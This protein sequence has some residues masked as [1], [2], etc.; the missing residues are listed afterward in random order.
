MTHE[1]V[2]VIGASSG[3]GFELVKQFLAEG[4]LVVASSRNV[5]PL[6]ELRAMYG[7]NLKLISMD[8]T[9]S[10]SVQNAVSEIHNQ[11]L[12]IEA[13]LINA[14]GYVPVS[15]TQISED[16]ALS[17]MKVN[18]LGPVSVTER[19]LPGMLEKGHGHIVFVA[20]VA[21]YLGLP[22]SL[23][24]G[25]SKAALINFAEGLRV[26]L[27]K[28]GIKIQLVNPGFVR[29]PLT[30]NNTFKMPF[31]MGASE[32]ATRIVKGME[33]SKFEISFPK[34]FTYFL[35]LLQMLPYGFTLKFLNERTVK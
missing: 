33:G 25:P 35:R 2:W 26:S 20:S 10:S 4:R 1:P 32:A 16:V 6:E 23:A 22:K 3:I 9:S 5:S 24:Y 27:Q 19:I 17:M 12:E 11:D 31:L 15:E 14:G 18:Y 29:T 28:T 8:V 13:V 30:A 21:G 34:R 7:E